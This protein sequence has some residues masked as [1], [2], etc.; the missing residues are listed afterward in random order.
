LCRLMVWL[1]WKIMGQR[2]GGKRG[3]RWKMESDSMA[4]GFVLEVE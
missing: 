2:Y 1:A 3:K 4:I